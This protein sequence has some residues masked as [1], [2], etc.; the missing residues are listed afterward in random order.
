[1][2]SEF[3][4]VHCDIVMASFLM[5]SFKPLLIVRIWEYLIT[6]KSQYICLFYHFNVIF[7]SILFKPSQACKTCK[8]LSLVNNINQSC[9]DLLIIC[10]E[11]CPKNLQMLTREICDFVDKILYYQLMLFSFYVSKISE[12]IYIMHFSFLHFTNAMMGKERL[13]QS[14]AFKSIKNIFK[15]SRLWQRNTS[16]DFMFSVFTIH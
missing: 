1:M 14:S 15:A 16:A 12:F 6:T 8:I 2:S 9:L 10:V 11:Y 7:S 5:F 4:V 13:T 3:F